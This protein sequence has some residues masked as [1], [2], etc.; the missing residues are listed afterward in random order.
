MKQ[1]F[2][3]ANVWIDY[4]WRR[5]FSRTTG[6]HKKKAL[7]IHNLKITGTR[8]TLTFPLLYEISSH[9]KDYSILQDMLAD[10]FG[11]FEFSKIKRD[12]RLNRAGRRKVDDIYNQIV[13]MRQTRD[14][15]LVNSPHRRGH[16]CTYRIA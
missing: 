6:R 7:L 9:F 5:N 8:V 15:I 4:S 11:A 12:Y 16:R 10:G 14:Q 13:N 1:I 3:D 2:F